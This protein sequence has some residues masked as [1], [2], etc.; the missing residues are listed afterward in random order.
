MKNLRAF[1]YGCR[2]LAAFGALLA[3]MT[4]FT[5]LFSHNLSSSK[6]G[7][8]QPSHSFM[9]LATPKMPKRPGIAPTVK[10]A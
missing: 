2:T 1:I 9:S 10:P 3:I 7:W 8:V 4:A 6:A 5:P